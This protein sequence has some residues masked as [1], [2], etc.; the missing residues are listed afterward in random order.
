MS[1]RIALN[2][3]EWPSLGLDPR[4]DDQDPLNGPR[5]LALSGPDAF[6]ATYFSGVLAQVS[7]RDE[8]EETR[9]QAHSVRRIP[10]GDQAPLTSERRGER[11]F[12]DATLGL[13]GWQSCASCHPDGRADGLNWD[14][15]NDGVGNPSNAKSLLLAHQT[16]PSMISGVRA[17]AAT[18]VR[19]GFRYILFGSPGEE[20]ARDIDAYLKALRPEPSPWREAAPPATVERGRVLFES[21]R[22]GC[23]SCHPAPLF[24]D[25]RM[26]DV[27]SKAASDRRD[28][29]DTP[30]LVEIWRTAPYLHDGRY[31]T[32]DE[33]LRDGRH[34]HGRG[35]VETLTPGDLDD[36]IA[37]LRTL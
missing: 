1:R 23:A 34:G 2:P 37:Y 26:H 25:L 14:L 21:P 9:T 20:A 19:S 28:T 6:V 5:G 24:T 33:L 15:L 16:P 31:A 12:H 17:D 22:I 3:P 35:A 8:G 30:T 36:L 11:A 7:I 10:L 29:F 27:G 32:L 13:Q 4:P 18:A